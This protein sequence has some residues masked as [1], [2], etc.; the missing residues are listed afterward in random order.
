MP[1]R[2]HIALQGYFINSSGSI[3]LQAP[4]LS[5]ALGTV[6][7]LDGSIVIGGT[8]VQP[9]W[10]RIPYNFGFAEGLLMANHGTFDIH[11][12]TLLNNANAVADLLYLRQ[13]VR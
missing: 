13:I 2:F 12:L 3:D 11:N 5:L 10:L 8:P 9:A 6:N 7:A 1:P 4:G